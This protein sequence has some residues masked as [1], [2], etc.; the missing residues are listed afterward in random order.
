DKSAGTTGTYRGPA[1]ESPASLDLLFGDQ[2]ITH[3]ALSP[4][5]TII[6]RTSDND[7]Q[8]KSKFISRHHAQITTDRARCI[9]EDLNSTNGV[10][11]GSRRV[12]Q[13]VLR[14]G[15]VIHLGEHK[16][17]YR[18][19]RPAVAD[20]QEQFAKTVRIP[21]NLRIDDPDAEPDD[22]TGWLGDDGPDRSDETTPGGRSKTEF[23]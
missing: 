20:R 8:I 3:F 12:K 14:D 13:H 16:L 17:V 2:L 18:D 7:L 9:I 21:E 23:G 19:A 5:R 4:G 10:F 11:I 1:S 15:G 22:D 6:G